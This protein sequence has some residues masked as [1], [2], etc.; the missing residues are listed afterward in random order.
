MTKADREAL[1]K[2]FDMT[3]PVRSRFGVKFGPCTD[4]VEKASVLRFA[5]RER[6]RR[7]PGAE[8]DTRRGTT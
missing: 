7:P 8:A 5:E 4:Y 6:P 1:R 3:V 2:R